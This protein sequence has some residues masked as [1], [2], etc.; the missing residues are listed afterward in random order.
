M[1]DCQNYTITSDNTGTGV[2]ISAS[3]VTVK[4]CNINKFKTAISA[5]GA[6]GLL[7]VNNTIR[8]PY[9]GIELLG[10]ESSTIFGNTLNSLSSGTGIMLNGSS[11]NTIEKNVLETNQYSLVLWKSDSNTISNNRFHNSINEA[12]NVISSSGNAFNNNDLSSSP[13]R[14]SA[15]SSLLMSDGN[16]TFYGNNF[17]RT[18]RGVSCRN[19]MFSDNGNN[20][21]ITQAGCGF[22]CNACVV[23]AD[24]WS[25]KY[26][27]TN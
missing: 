14:N 11:K 2:R 9:G 10:V 6:N 16:N 21:C 23:V 22:T 8:G 7:I 25:S 17:C 18:G 13:L 24:D 19:G 26:A 5:T 3:G 27:I 1:L 12:A 15:S 4:N 20:T